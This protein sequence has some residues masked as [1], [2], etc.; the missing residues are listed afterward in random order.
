MVEGVFKINLD[1]D[2]L[3]KLRNKVNDQRYISYEKT[4]Y[5]KDKQNKYIKHRAWD[6]ICAIMDRLDD[7][8]NHLNGLELNAGRYK[9]SAFDFYEFMNNASVVVDCIKELIKIF[10]VPNDKIKRSTEIFDLL[11]SDGKGTDENYFEYLRSLCSVHPVETSRHK[12]YQANDFE[13]SPYVLWNDRRIR[14]NDDCDIYAVV[15]TN[16]D[17]VTNKRVR[18]YISQIFEY[19]KT[20]LTFVAE[21]TKAIDK[22]QK[23]VLSDLSSR[24][25]KKEEE[26]DNYIDYLRTLDKE[27][28]ERDGADN[29]SEFDFVIKLFE[30]K[31]SNP[32]NNM[33][34]LY[35]NVL[36][37]AIAFEHNRL[38]NMSYMGFKNNGLLH[39]ECN[40]ETS[41]YNE[42]CSPHSGS[43]EQIKYSYNLEKISYLS[44]D[45][46]HDNK[47]WAYI[48]LKKARIF[49]DKYVSFE[50]A[51][52]DFEH[53]ALVHLALYMDCL[54]NK[55][56]INKNIPNDL[57]YRS[58]VLSDEEWRKLIF[59]K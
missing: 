27:L 54:E 9:Q 48:Q 5:F 52:G 45:S 37:Y 42:L 1:T 19:V 50:G 25:I 6:K 58:R 39:P 29:F 22:Y 55:C 57:K 43:A 40:I 38:Q 11:G 34:N 18:I 8:V 32:L 17:G 33:M 28:K 14:W 53:Y 10:D 15:Y 23:Q 41:L 35:L 26:F 44:Y 59:D 49:L 12:R 46:G 31:L 51:K 21:I 2:V 47:Q 20:R 30:L 16:K 13:C 3:M 56:L 24:P 7:T 4:L 36:K